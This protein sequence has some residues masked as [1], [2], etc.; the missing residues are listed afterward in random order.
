[1]SMIMIRRHVHVLLIS[2]YWLLRVNIHSKNLESLD[3][4]GTLTRYMKAC[5]IAYYRI[6][7]IS[8]HNTTVLNR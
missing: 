5:C 8:V 4:L 6:K 7:I 3:H 1:M 2:Q